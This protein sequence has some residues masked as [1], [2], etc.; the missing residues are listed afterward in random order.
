MLLYRV[1][2]GLVL[3]PVAVAA[4]FYLSSHAFAA[5]FWVVTALAVYEW[6]GL[7]KLESVTRKLAYVLLYLGVCGV[8]YSLPSLHTSLIQLGCVLWVL[9]ALAVYL[10]PRGAQIYRGWF[11][12][13]L[14]LVLVSIAWLALLHVRAVPNGA[15]WVVWMFLVVWGADV[16]A[17]FAGRGFGKHKLAPQVSPGKTWEGVLGGMLLPGVVC[18]ALVLMYAPKGQIWVFITLGLIVVSVFGDLFES[19][20]KRATGVKDSGTL[21][22]GHGGMLDRIDSILAVLPFFAAAH[23]SL[24]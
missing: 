15:Y 12:G 11:L 10:F 7:L 22:P 23:M 1:I 4:V 9:C 8:L 14:G 24:A 2:T 18:G 19:V 3:A 21:L 20:L 17:Y 13:A 16:G 6:A 5:V